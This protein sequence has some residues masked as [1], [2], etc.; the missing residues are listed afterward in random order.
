MGSYS[1]VR[2]ITPELVNTTMEAIMK[3]MAKALQAEG[4]PFTAV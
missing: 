2:K 1:P 4:V 3:P